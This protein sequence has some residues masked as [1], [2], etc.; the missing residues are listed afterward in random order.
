[1]IVLEHQGLAI[2]LRSPRLPIEVLQL[3]TKFNRLMN[4]R[5]QVRKGRKC[6]IYERHYIEMLSD[7]TMVQLRTF[8][9]QAV[10]KVIKLTQ[11][12]GT[13]AYVRFMDDPHKITIQDKNRR[14]CEIKLWI[15]TDAGAPV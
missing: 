12:N 10:G 1:M 9:R 5:L 6:N 15:D 14:I 13:T 8:L 4:G 7:D 2:Q 3:P 11:Y